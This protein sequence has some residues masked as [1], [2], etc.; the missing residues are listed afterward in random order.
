MSMYLI[1]GPSHYLI[2]SLV[3]GFLGGGVFLF[4]PVIFLL[5]FTVYINNVCMS[6]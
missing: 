6:D 1:L 2:D 4:N 3:C 5:E